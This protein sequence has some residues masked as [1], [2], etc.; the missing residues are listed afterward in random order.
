MHQVSIRKVAREYKEEIKSAARATYELFTT[1][2]KI[3]DR[4]F[5]VSDPHWIRRIQRRARRAD[6]RYP[7][8]EAANGLGR[9]GAAWPDSGVGAFL[10][11][12]ARLSDL[13]GDYADRATTDRAAMHHNEQ[14]CPAPRMLRSASQAVSDA[15]SERRQS[16]R[17]DLWPMT[18]FFSRR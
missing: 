5:T 15:A 13:V 9:N 7:N 1:G 12:A 16:S 11:G 10:R 8:K 18:A 6:E 3:P 17:G 14:R 4:N 2:S